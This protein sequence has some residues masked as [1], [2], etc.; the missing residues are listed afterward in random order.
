MAT[1]FMFGK[2]SAEAMKGMSADRT[3]KAAALVKKYGGEVKSAY[4]LLGEHDLVLIVELPDTGQA[5]KTS[6]ALSK[7]TGIA[8]TT[9]PAVSVEEFDK[10]MK[11]V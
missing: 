4:A 6:V 5:M 9:S 2:Y 1:Y 10:M 7:L 11:E 3:E 8:F